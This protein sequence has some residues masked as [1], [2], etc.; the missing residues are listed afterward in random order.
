M[1]MLSA[2]L[3]ARLCGPSVYA[4]YVLCVTIEVVATSLPNAIN[5]SPMLS[6]GPGLPKE[7][8]QGFFARVLR[9][10]VR[11]SLLLAVVGGCAAPLLTGLSLA[12][13]TWL[14]FALALLTSGVLNAVRA[15]QQ[16]RFCSR[17]AFWADV[18]ALLLPLLVV[19]ALAGSS[20]EHIL[21]GYFIALACGS[22]FAAMGLL[23]RETS[24]WADAGDVPDSVINRQRHMGVP[25]AVGSVANSACSR[26]QPFVLQ[27]A[28]GASAVSVFGAAATTIGPM[29]LLAMA[30][31]SVVRPRFALLAGQ[32]DQVAMRSLL[33]DSCLLLAGCG[34]VG[35]AAAWLAGHWLIE[36]TFGAE[37]AFVGEI[38]PLAVVFASLES[39]AAVLCV[40][41]QTL[42]V[43]GAARV[44]R[45]RVAVSA[46]A[47]GIV[48]PACHLAHAAGAFT[49]LC[50]T[51]LLF[52][53]LVYQAMRP[54]IASGFDDRALL[55]Q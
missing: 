51:E 16:A 21:C 20:P 40:A 29:R 38:L 5:L 48:W 53:V 31:S 33:R 8:R 55:G 22:G 44:T 11:W 13:T 41:L 24:A 10:H 25:M 14:A 17:S 26:V 42:R 27:A 52:L 46:L 49:A 32:R 9:T 34:V 28:A 15:R 7:H 18:V 23:V 4:A 19:L 45:L 47:L 1:R 43:D 35:L 12:A 2:V 36:S 6:I 54:T 3:V 39:V 30:L 50:G 37:F